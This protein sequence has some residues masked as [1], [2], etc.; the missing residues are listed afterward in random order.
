MEQRILNTLKPFRKLGLTRRSIAKKLGINKGTRAKF[1]AAL[2][3]LTEQDKL[4]LRGDRYLPMDEKQVHPG[5]IIKV[6]G[7]FG[8]ARP[9]GWDRDVFVPG[10][11][12]QGAIPGD[13]V[14][15]RVMKSSRKDGLEEGEVLR[16]VQTSD[17]PFPGVLQAEDGVYTVAP[18]VGMRLPLP[19]I[20]GGLAGAKPG[21]KVMV[22]MVH[23][24]ERHSDHTVQVVSSLGC[25]SDPA[26]CSLAVLARLDVPI[27]FPAEALEQA[28]AIAASAEIHPK[29]LAARLDLRDQ[30]IFTIDGA[31]SKDLD[32]AIS[33]TRKG[34][35]WELGVH[36]ADVSH[37]VTAGSPLDEEALIRGTSVYYADQVVPML[38]HQLSNGICS[39]NPGEDRLTF[40]AFIQLDETGNRTGYRFAKSVIHSR[41]KGV[42]GELNA[43]TDGSEDAQLT[44]KYAGVWEQVTQMRELA[45]LL[46]AKR[47]AGGKMVLGSTESKIIIG[48]DGAVADITVRERGFFEELIEEFML[49]AN[50]AAACFAIEKG[51][52]FIYRVHE[53]P[54][55]EKLEQLY[56]LLERLGVR[57]ARPAGDDLSGALSQILREVEG[58]AYHAIINTL[59]LRSMAKAKYSSGHSGHF[60]LKLENYA[61]FTSP[62]RRYPDLA[63]HRIMSSVLSGAKPENLHR[64]YSAFAHKA[65]ERSTAREIAAVTA[66]RDCTA[67]YK[68][69]YMRRFL[70]EELDGVVSGCIGRGLYVQLQ[71]TCEGMVQLADFPPGDW[72]FDG[73]ID[74]I[75]QTGGKHI[76]LGDRVRIRV[77]AADVSSG[78]VDFALVACGV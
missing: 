61:H 21:D 67:C 46:M 47:L 36:I 48:E 72:N 19:V 13:K 11:F 55:P 50:E 40:S 54:N 33:L 37:Y 18:D 9:Q 10:R 15:L 5:E 74:F 12:L 31:D 57:F 52:P 4:L 73:V 34:A 3:A 65:A 77:L 23:R 20:K 24:G 39:L 22:T 25:S 56:E 53:D 27:P 71:N 78:R 49:Q 44:A 45:Q 76:R 38:P 43:L 17:R 68:A 30:I 41:V 14:T 42:Y 62:I 51:M 26:A 16:V 7:T 63:I 6:S 28:E 2:A 29:E 75:D 60:G 8:F 32:D 35:G 59:V 64:R 70:G 1:D 69:S 58:G 66:E